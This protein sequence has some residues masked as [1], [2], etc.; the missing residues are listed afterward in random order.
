MSGWAPPLMSQCVKRRTLS[1]FQENYDRHYRR[2]LHDN[3]W[4]P[5]VDTGRLSQ[6]GTGAFSNQKAGTAGFAAK[7]TPDYAALRGLPRLAGLALAL[8][9]APLFEGRRGAEVTAGRVT[10]RWLEADSGPSDILKGRN[11]KTATTV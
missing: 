7:R 10:Q 2:R 9:L 3:R 5:L 1:F 8:P 6:V 11:S 4:R